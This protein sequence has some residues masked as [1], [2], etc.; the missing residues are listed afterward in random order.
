MR[1][2]HEDGRYSIGTPYRI[3]AIFMSVRYRH[4]ISGVHWGG[5]RKLL[6]QYYQA[7]SKR[8]YGAEI[9]GSAFSSV[10]KKLNIIQNAV[11]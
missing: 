6:I 7:A 3:S 10:L 4:R 11:L 1:R 5:N 2:R 9:Y 8:N